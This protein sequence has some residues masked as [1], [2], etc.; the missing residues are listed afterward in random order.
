MEGHL[1]ILI[2]ISDIIFVLT[3]FSQNWTELFWTSNGN[4]NLL[5]ILKHMIFYD[6][7][8]MSTRTQYDEIQN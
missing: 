1:F 2:D 3:D 5:N 8:E 6:V 4:N 7:Q